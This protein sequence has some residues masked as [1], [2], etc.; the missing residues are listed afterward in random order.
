MTAGAVHQGLAARI[1]AYEYAHADDLLDAAAANGEKPLIVGARLGHRPAQPRRRRPQRRRLRRARRGDPRAP[2]GRHDRV[3]LEDQRRRRGPDPGRADRQPGPPAQGL[4][5]RRLHGRSASPPT[6]TSACPTSTSPTARWCVVV[7]SEGKG[8]SRLV[9][10]TCDQLVSIPMANQLES[11]NAGVA[12]CVALYAIAEAAPLTVAPIRDVLRVLAYAGIWLAVL[13]SLI[14]LVLFL[15]SSRTVVLAS[16]DAVVRP[17]SRGRRS[18]TPGPVL[19]DVRVDTGGAIGVDVQLGKTDADSTDELV[20]RYAYIAGQ[21]EGQIAKVG[22]AVQAMAVDAALRGAVLGLVPVLVWLLVG[23]AR[24]RELVGRFG[25][26]PAVVALGA[27]RRCS[28]SRSGSRGASGERRSAADERVGRRSRS[29]SARTCRCPSELDAVEVRGD[30]T[31]VADPPADR[32]RGRHLRQEQGVLRR[33]RGRRRRARA[34][35]A[36]GG[37]DRGR[38]RLRPARQHRHG[39]GRPGGRRRRRCDRGVRRRRRHLDR[40]ELGGVLPGLGQRGVRRPRPL[41]RRR[42]PRPRLLRARLPR[43]TT[44]GPCSTARWSTAR[45][46]PPARR[47]RPA[48]QR[49]RQLA[50]RDRPELRRGRAAARRRRVRRRRAAERRCWSTTPTSAARRSTAAAPTWCSAATCTSG[51]ARSRVVGRERRRPATRY[52]TG[53]TGGA[54]YAIAIGSKP[55]RAAEVSLVTYRDGRPVGIQWVV[56][57]TN[58]VF[59]VGEY[60]ELT[61]PPSP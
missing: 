14:G 16:H 38:V 51:S 53:T 19:P 30:V 8:L 4:P 18:C 57:Q 49:A 32:E 55:R 3:R 42:Q 1:P 7:G 20:Q 54:A 9:A 10:E 12:A 31:T 35:R 22:H 24:R 60:V 59:E 26:A 46:A 47:R 43:A 27:G 40:R 15:T 11:L 48:L 45:A 61:Y 21:P 36:G 37:R 56:L 17:T 34:A 58:G 39:P 25:L 52:T 29:S 44:A 23:P 33:R 50:R 28:A 13:P 6:A 41:G 2:R 5:G